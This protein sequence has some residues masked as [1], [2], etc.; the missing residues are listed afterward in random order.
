MN[1]YLVDSQTREEGG[2][3]SFRNYWILSVD[4]VLPRDAETRITAWSRG[5]TFS[6]LDD[7]EYWQEDGERLVAENMTMKIPESHIEVLKHY[8]ECYSYEEDVETYI[9]EEVA[10]G[11]QT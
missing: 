3:E 11:K 10:I 1:Y 9:N 7:D 4:K 2:F 6:E 5:L 8:F